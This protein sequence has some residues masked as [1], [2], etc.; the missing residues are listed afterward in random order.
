[1]I[2]DCGEEKNQSRKHILYRSS[3]YRKALGDP[4]EKK[5]LQMTI[6]RFTNRS[7]MCYRELPRENIGHLVASSGLAGLI[8]VLM[9]MKHKKIPP[10][11]NFNDRMPI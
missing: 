10:T 4:I 3:W 7:N 8:K 9:A 1:M 11:I 5:G 6:Q 2:V